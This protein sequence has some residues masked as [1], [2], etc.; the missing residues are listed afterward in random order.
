MTEFNLRYIPYTLRSRSG[1]RCELTVNG[2]CEPRAIRNSGWNHTTWGSR[3][4]VGIVENVNTF[5]RNWEW[6][7]DSGSE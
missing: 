2:P 7:N 4:F 6:E 3:N 1:I 5:S